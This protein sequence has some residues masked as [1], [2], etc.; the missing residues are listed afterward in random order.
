MPAIEGVGSEVARLTGEKYEMGMFKHNAVKELAWQAVYML[1]MGREQPLVHPQPN[2][3]PGTPSWSWASTSQKMIFHPDPD[4]STN[5]VECLAAKFSISGSQLRVSGRLGS[6]HVQKLDFASEYG[7][8]SYSSSPRTFRATSVAGTLVF[9]TLTDTLPGE[10]GYIK[11]LRWLRFHHP[12]GHRATGAMVISP[13]DEAKNVYRRTGWIELQ[14][15]FSFEEE[16]QDI[17]IV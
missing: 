12:A 14:D 8:R 2:R 11:C 5:G 1:R 4:L 13:V 3:L 7:F 9:D 10:G 15:D 17:V 16:Y 6:L